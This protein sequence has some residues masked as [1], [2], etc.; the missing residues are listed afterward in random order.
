MTTQAELKELF[1]YDGENL[2]RATKRGGCAAGSVAGFIDVA[3]YRW[4][5]V[6]KIRY[7]VS[8]LVWL[9]VHGDWPDGEIDHVNGVRDDNRIGNLRDVSRLIQVKNAKK[10][11]DNSSG[12]NGVSWN[13]ACSKWW[14]YIDVDKKR[15]DLGYYADK[16]KAAAKRRMA[17]VIYGGFTE[18]HGA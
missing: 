17:E 14:A 1:R 10:R 3:G 9:Y 13:K 2:I 6:N 16:A 4:A 18:R 11:K 8:H 7:A 5:K 12:V 15:I